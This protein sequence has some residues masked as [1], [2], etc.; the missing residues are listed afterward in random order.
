MIHRKFSYQ[1]FLE[2][3]LSPSPIHHIC[4]EQTVYRKLE[5]AS[6][7]QSKTFLSNITCHEFSLQVLILD[8]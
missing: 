8:E 1:K 5:S 2:D 3:L 7:P 4:F 6:V